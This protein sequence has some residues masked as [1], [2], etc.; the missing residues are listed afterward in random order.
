MGNLWIAYARICLIIITILK[1]IFVSY[2]DNFIGNWEY[3]LQESTVTVDN[4]YQGDYVQIDSGYPER[5]YGLKKEYDGCHMVL[6]AYNLRRH[7]ADPV[8]PDSKIQQLRNCLEISEELNLS[9]I[10]R[11]AYDFDGKYTDPDFS[12]ILS[13]IRQI[14]SVLNSYK[15]CLAGVQ[16]GMLGAYGEWSQT[17]YGKA[18][19]HVRLIKAWEESLDPQIAISVRRQQF[20]REAADAGLDTK[21]LG[22][23]NDGLFSSSTD[24]GTYMGDYDREQDLEWSRENIQVPFN[25]GEMPFISEYT[26][27]TNVVKEAKQLNLSYLNRQYNLKV[28]D[29]WKTQT[30]GGVSADEYIRGH[31][32]ARLYVSDMKISKNYRYR[33][34]MSVELEL[35]NSGFAMLGDGYKAYLCIRYNG[36]VVQQEAKLTVNSKESITVFGDLNNAFYDGSPQEVSIGL[37]LYRESQA[38]EYCFQLVNEGN[39]FESGTNWFWND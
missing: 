28:W 37:K 26:D 29:Y 13:H 20:I 23:Y 15:S 14:S 16:A 11:A 5:L 6:L 18:D 9:V 8:I 32:G 30:Y 12:V 39:D 1:S 24:L 3:E 19:H 4:P 22:I 10:F 36:N 21:R 31:L 27:I 7:A 38:E 33:K 25:G 35:R 2:Q 17:S 34:K